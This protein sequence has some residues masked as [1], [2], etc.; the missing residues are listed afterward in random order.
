MVEERVRRK[1]AAILVADVVGYSRLMA[2][3]E[4]GTLARLKALRAQSIDPRIAEHRGRIVKET[5]DGLL[6]EFVSVIDAV[7]CAVDLQRG[8][9]EKNTDVPDDRRMAFRMGINLGDIIVE[10]HDIYGDGVNIAARLESVAEPGGVCIAGK[11]YDEVKGRLDL[12]YES[13]GEQSVKN[14][15]GTIRVYRIGIGSLD[16]SSLASAAAILD[17]PAVA[18]LPFVNMSGDPEQEYFADG[19]SEDIITALSYWRSFPV[20]ARNSTFAYK[21]RSVDVR[22]VATEL[23]ARY[24]LE[25]SVRRSGERVRITTQLIDAM[26]GHHVWADKFDRVLEDIFELQD[27][28]TQRIAA[29]VAP[30]V[31]RAEHKRLGTKRTRSLSAWE[32]YLRGMSHINDVT[33][34]G[35]ARAREMFLHAIELD[36]TYSDAFTGLAFSHHRDINLQVTEDFENSCSE[37]LAAARQAVAHDP[38]SSSAHV[39]LGI[40]Y[41]HTSKYDLAIEET[42]TAVS[43]NPSSPL[44]HIARGTSLSLADRPREGIPHLQKALELSPRD[45][46]L[47]QYMTLLA[48]AHLNAGNYEVAEGWARKAV[49]LRPDYPNARFCRAVCLGHLGRDED[50]REELSECERIS[51]DYIG[52]RLSDPT[53]PYKELIRDGL[54]RA[55]WKG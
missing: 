24:V 54:R 46:W 23:G 53:D 18:V 10:D 15:P 27:E 8:L 33:K 11:V 52:K 39:I 3:D 45:P 5:G 2:A 21:G 12:R 25:G 4:A 9:A 42:K 37:L 17:R 16:S 44:A 19:L 49:L 22:K 41:Q 43:L 50:A 40:A 28:I 35:N 55:G 1:L 32:Y 51:V 31:E 29:A 30:E 38:A 13:L 48:G 47:Y 34:D 14:I 20:I 6:V 26:T 36:P 7:A